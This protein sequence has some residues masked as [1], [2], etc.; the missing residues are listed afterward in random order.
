ML[1]SVYLHRTEAHDLGQHFQV[2][3]DDGRG[4]I[5][6]L[7]CPCVDLYESLAASSVRHLHIGDNRFACKQL[8]LLRFVVTFQRRGF[9][10]RIEDHIR[11]TVVHADNVEA[12]PALDSLT[13]FISDTHGKYGGMSSVANIVQY[14]HR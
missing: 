13:L 7:F 10:C 5:H 12:D 6:Y 14:V 1:H 9:Q 2:A 8:F 4:D 3:G 11:L